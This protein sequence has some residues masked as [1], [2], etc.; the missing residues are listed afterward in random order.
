MPPDVGGA[1]VFPVMGSAAIRDAILRRLLEVFGGTS[2]DAIPFAHLY[3]ERVFPADVYLSMLEYLPPMELYA[4]DNPRKYARAAALQGLLHVSSCRYT[5]ALHERNLERLSGAAREIWSGVAAALTAPELKERIFSRLSSDLCRR[6]HLGERE[7]QQVVVY[8]RPSLVR[9]LSGY[10]IAPHPDTRAKVVTAQFYLAP[11]ES[12]RALGTT[13]YRRHLFDPRNL[14]SLKNMFE[15]VKQFDF[16]PNSGYAFAVGR[17]S[18]HGRERVP[19][20][21]GERNSILL[22]YYSDPSREW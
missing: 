12:Q 7:L 14:I 18:W 9:D 20:D 5:F 17:H 22:F 6:F 2:I 3:V 19:N 10:W 1:V 4:P 21:A 11:D 13:L 15:K 16:L 8:P